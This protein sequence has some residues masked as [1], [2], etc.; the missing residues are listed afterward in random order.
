[1]AGV[2]AL[3]G[4]W[5]YVDGKDFDKYMSEIGVSFLMRQTAKLITPRIIISEVNGRWT[6]RSETHIKNVQYD[7]IPGEEFD[8]TTPDGREVKS[9]IKFENGRWIH[10]SR[11]KKGKESVVTRYV[12][13]AG[14]HQV[15]LTCGDVRA[16]RVYKRADT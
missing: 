16:T 12:D 2:E 10:S 4:T 1:M 7:F 15:I 9:L 11:D 5:D 8:E 13:E 14:L 3:K 6:V